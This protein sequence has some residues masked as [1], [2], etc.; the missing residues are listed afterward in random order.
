MKTNTVMDPFLA[1][2]MVR[3]IQAVRVMKPIQVT[4]A[5]P[6][7]EPIQATKAVFGQEKEPVP[8][9]ELEREWGC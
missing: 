8:A 4:E 6:A 3:R 7:M 9:M 1:M 2:E 5:I